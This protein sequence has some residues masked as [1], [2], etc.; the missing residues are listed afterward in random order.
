MKKALQIVCIVS[1]SMMIMQQ[2]AAYQQNWFVSYAENWNEIKAGCNAQ[3]II[4][5]NTL[6]ANNTRVMQWKVN[7]QWVIV[8]WTLTNN[9]FQTQKQITIN[10][11]QEIN[12][13]VALQGDKNSLAAIVVNGTI[14]REK[15]FIQQKSLSF[16]E[17]VT[18]QRSQ[19]RTMDTFKPYT[20]N[21]LYGPKINS[22]SANIMFYILG[23]IGMVVAYTLIKNKK[24]KIVISSS[25]LVI[26]RIIYDIRMTAEFTKYTHDNYQNWIK[27]DEAEKTYK[28]I[29]S[30]FPSFVKDTKK[31]VAKHNI[32]TVYFK[33][34]Q[35]WPL[36]WYIVYDLY[37]TRLVKEIKD[38]DAI[39]TWNNNLE[40]E[41][42]IE[43]QTIKQK[44]Q[45]EKYPQWFIYILQKWQ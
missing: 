41:N 20:I 22:K 38:A 28:T 33:T 14:K 12:E 32:K 31:I 42:M 2:T 29:Y 21:L 4:V 36:K 44:I 45:S 1:L 25:I 27:P 37:P 16:I 26:L 15:L 24:K 39:I 40:N 7:G 30:N 18:N 19:F 8:L 35:E 3:C 5:G 34:N 6:E 43:N 9:Q 23:I 10:N 11:N 13:I 17:K